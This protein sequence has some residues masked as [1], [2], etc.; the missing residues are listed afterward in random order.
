MPS[1]S[2]IM[3]L[4]NS[5]GFL[6][7]AVESVLN[8]SFRDFELILI[9]DG[10]TDASPRI[11][12]KY[13][14]ADDRVMVIHQP[15]AGVSAAR[16]RGIETA[17]G[18][19]LAFIDSD[20]EYLPK[21]LEKNYALAVEHDADIVKYGVTRCYLSID[22]KSMGAW[23][24]PKPAGLYDNTQIIERYPELRESGVVTFIWD[25]LF[26]KTLI[27]ENDIKFDRR[28][29]VYEDFCFN[30][31]C[32]PHVRKLVVNPDIYYLYF[33]RQGYSASTKHDPGRAESRVVMS[34]KE[35]VFFQTC[36]LEKFHPGYW[37]ELAA[38]YLFMIILD[39]FDMLNFADYPRKTEFLDSVREQKQFS[40]IDES[41]WPRILLKTG[42]YGILVVLF[43]LRSYQLL[44][45]MTKTRKAQKILFKI[46]KCIPVSGN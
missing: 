15:N 31:D 39:A 19:Y 30:Y 37:N 16:N 34:C 7:R 28:V 9:N 38:R 23:R 25:G 13:A 2:V 17:E 4:Y 1:V 20:D 33:V 42:K 14:A 45:S 29:K 3:P 43:K 41:G 8:Q 6:P 40:F 46:L 27:A 26:K 44:M 32:L 36:G 11:C 10:S 5:S 22:R 21:L 12:E 35:Y 18:E 24:L